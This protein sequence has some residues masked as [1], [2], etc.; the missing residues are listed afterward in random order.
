MAVSYLRSRG[1]NAMSLTGGMQWWSM[2]WNSAEVPLAK[3]KANL[4]QVR[5]TGKGCL[6]YVVASEGE[7][8][9]IDPSADPQVY[10]DIAAGHNWEIRD[11]IDTHVHADH[12]TR[13]RMLAEQTGSRYLLPAQDRVSFN[14]EPI[15]DG[16]TIHIGKANLKALHT[17]GHTF[18][19]TSF[20]LDDEVLFTGDTLFLTSIGRPDL[21]ASSKETEERA[22]MLYK[23]LRELSNLPEE[24][25][26]LPAHTNAPVPFD[27]VSLSATLSE[28]KENIEVLKMV[29]DKFVEFLLNHIPQT[30]PNHLQIV[31]LNEAGSFPDGD[32]TSLEAGAN[33]CAI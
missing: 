18:E 17:P 11:I 5:R 26:V 6:S 28:V 8:A 7:A 25:L 1:M 4:I 29:E 20:L 10:L 33:R 12:L 27:E 15:S 13:G 9:V 22:H 14:F 31:Q 24:T 2:A 16:D 19:S 21:K 23:S 32:V 30:P 3:S